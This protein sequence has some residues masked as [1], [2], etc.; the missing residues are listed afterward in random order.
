MPPPCDT[1]NRLSRG[2]EEGIERAAQSLAT[3]YLLHSLSSLSLQ[4]VGSLGRCFD[5]RSTMSR[6]RHL[7]NA[8][9]IVDRSLAA[10][11]RAVG[12]KRFWTLIPT[13][14]THAI[15][16]A[17]SCHTSSEVGFCFGLFIDTSKNDEIVFSRDESSLR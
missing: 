3:V 13:N 14:H 11:R 9:P 7:A 8:M 10:P 17:R 15:F 2:P 5:R 1:V 6:W 16:T 12:I 4:F